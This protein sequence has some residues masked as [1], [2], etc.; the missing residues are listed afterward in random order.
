MKDILL[1]C[2]SYFTRSW[3]TYFSVFS[4]FFFFYPSDSLIVIAPMTSQGSHT[5]LRAKSNCHLI[6]H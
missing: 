3:I 2:D 1:F 6:S 4:Y 5:N